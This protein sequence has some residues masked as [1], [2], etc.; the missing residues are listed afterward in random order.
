MINFS[1]FQMDTK[2]EVETEVKNSGCINCVEFM[3]LL[4]FRRDK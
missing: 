1:I 3:G 4:V 2:T